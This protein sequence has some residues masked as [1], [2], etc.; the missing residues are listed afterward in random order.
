MMNMMMK[1]TTTLEMDKYMRSKIIS[2]QYLRHIFL[3]FSPRHYC[4]NESLNTNSEER[5]NA[6]FIDLTAMTQS[7]IK[8]TNSTK[9]L[10]IHM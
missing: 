1:T 8:D 5:P 4:C 9:T 3:K 2:D 10:T 6:N 7:T